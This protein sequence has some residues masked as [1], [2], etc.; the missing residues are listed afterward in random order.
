MVRARA[1]RHRPPAQISLAAAKLRA[2]ADLNQAKDSA[3][4]IASGGI[5]GHCR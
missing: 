3:L 5:P 1:F 2:L 4:W